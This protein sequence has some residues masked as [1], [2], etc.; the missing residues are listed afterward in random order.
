[1]WAK[2]LSGYLLLFACWPIDLASANEFYRW[3]DKEGTI[4]FADNLHS[5]PEPH[6][7]RE[8][9]T[10]PIREEITLISKIE[11]SN[12]SNPQRFILP[13]TWEA[14]RLLVDARVNDRI[15]VR[16]IVDTGAY[17]TV[18][19]AKLASRLGFDKKNSLSV[20]IHGVGGVVEGRLIEVDSLK[21]GEAEVRNFDLVIIEDSLGGRALLGADFLSRFQLELDFNRGQMVL[22]SGDGSYDGYPA[23]WWQEKFRLYERLKR[24]YERRISQNQDHMRTF[25]ASADGRNPEVQFGR[26]IDP[27]RPVLDEID[28]YQNYLGILANKLSAL[29]TRANRAALP[30][31]YRQ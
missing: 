26:G 10:V 6:H 19:P 21:V 2:F 27:M 31:M 13:L 15:P 4:N 23:E 18:I 25:R 14:G 17:I 7:S 22:R 24:N 11:S 28:E 1:M 29:Q 12:A 8:A 3:F 30:L 9:R 16:C 20:E 5:V